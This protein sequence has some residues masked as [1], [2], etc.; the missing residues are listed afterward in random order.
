MNIKELVVILLCAFSLIIGNQL[1]IQNVSF[2]VIILVAF[3]LGIL[4]FVLLS[5]EI[6][7]RIEKGG[8]RG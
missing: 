2:W 6:F 4:T 7:N 3:I 8:K 1:G 5:K